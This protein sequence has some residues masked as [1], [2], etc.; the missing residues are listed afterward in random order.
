MGQLF[1]QR[2]YSGL[3]RYNDYGD[4]MTCCCDRL[5]SN[6]PGEYFHKKKTNAS[7]QAKVAHFLN[8]VVAVMRKELDESRYVRVH[9]SFQSTSS[10]IFLTVNALNY[11]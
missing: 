5:P 3:A 7:G 8:P 9:C 11:C 2:P 10:C 1:I 4:T 6:V